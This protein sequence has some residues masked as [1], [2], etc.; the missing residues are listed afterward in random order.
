MP[1][2][3]TIV[4][5]SFYLPSI[6]QIIPL[7]DPDWKRIDDLFLQ[8]HGKRLQNAING[9]VL[10]E[11]SLFDIII[12]VKKGNIQAI[13]LLDFFNKLTTE[14]LLYVDVTGLRKIR[15][16]LKDLLLNFDSK[17][18]NFVGELAVLNNLMKSR[19]YNLIDVEASLPDSKKTIDFKIASKSGESPILVE[20]VNI[21]LDETRTDKDGIETFLT[22]RLSKK[23]E[24]KSTSI[25]FFL[26]PVIWGSAS[27]LKTYS[28]YFKE[29][30]VH[31][32][33]VLEP[34]AYLTFSDPADS[35]FMLHRFGSI[36]TLFNQN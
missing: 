36:S 30:T 7:S 14:I 16:N 11:A 31:I 34:V 35:N 13:R 10:I 23:K 28:D 25:S 5:I 19:S 8:K 18:L 9:V 21:H 4:N 20:V 33:S 1:V 6:M 22:H 29:N 12:E 27:A 26:I 3:S 32:Q 17:Y 15:K 24:S 2:N